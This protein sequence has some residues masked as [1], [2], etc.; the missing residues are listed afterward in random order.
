[1][2]VQEQIKQVKLQIDAIK[3]DQDKLQATRWELRQQLAALEAQAAAEADPWRETRRQ[4]DRWEKWATAINVSSINGDVARYVRHLEAETNRLESELAK[5]AS[6]RDM[7]FNM[8]N[9]KNVQNAQLDGKINE[10]EAELARRPV[11]WCIMHADRETR[12]LKHLIPVFFATEKEAE[13]EAQLRGQNF[14][15]IVPYTGQQS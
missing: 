11:V 4:I 10:L 12:S 5:T 6:V 2:S 1:M 3:A 14:Y 13:I 9:E 8:L 7:A 15:L